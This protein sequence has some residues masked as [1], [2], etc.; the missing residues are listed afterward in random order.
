MDWRT[1]IARHGDRLLPG[2]PW[3]RWTFLA[4]MLLAAVLRFW[5]Y[6]EIPYTHDEISALVR[7]FPTLGETIRTGVIALDTHPPGVQVFEWLW[8]RLFGM[9]EA[10]VK[11]PFTLLS[12]GALVLLFRFAMAWTGAVPAL[13]LTALMATLQ[14]SV[15]YGQIARP[16]AFGLFTTALLAD[17]LTRYLALGRRRALVGI[18][19]AAV[20]SA[21]THHFALLLAF[22]MGGSGLLLLR[23]GQRKP[24]LWMVGIVLLLYLPNVPIFI[25]Q[26]G[27]GGLGGWL[28]RPDRWWLADHAWWIAHT[29]WW[30]AAPLGLLALFAITRLVQRRNV[31]GNS[32]V[33]LFTWGLLPIAIGIGYSLW[34][35]PVVQHS[36]L[37]FSFPYLA[38]ALLSGMRGVP[39]RMALPL[40]AVICV[41]SVGTL[42]GTRQHY[43]VF[44]TSKYDAM[45]D[46]A[47]RWTQGNAGETLVLLDA[48][49]EVLDFH[50]RQRGLG[51]DDV[52]HVRLLDD[53]FTPGRLDTLL[54][55]S[56]AQRVFYGQSNGASA[57]RIARIQ[58]HFPHLVQRIDMAEGQVFVLHR[59]P[60]PEAISDRRFLTGACPICDPLP[61][62]EIHTDLPT[63][64]DS[65]WPRSWDHSGREY[66]VLVAM[67]LDTVAQR[68]DDLVEIHAR[69][70]LPG[71]TQ[72]VGLVVEL[73][74]GDSTV[75]YR[76]AELD[77]LLL[78]EAPQEV[79]LIVATRPG[80]AQLR[81]AP[82]L[83]RA[84]LHNRSGAAIG[85]RAMH[86]VLREGNPVVHALSG[87]IDGPWIYRPKGLV[88]W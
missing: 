79:T 1:H 57:E 37:L 81:D 61:G 84:Y 16:Y 63:R 24:Y 15:M 6:T 34:R 67:A 36:M 42:I 4:L 10:A 56:R 68:A 29:S 75:F 7:L 51:M 60:V 20:L 31:P 48:P 3:A 32:L 76:T 26:L 35:E 70:F 22:L 9:E 78:T 69:L 59:E 65:L 82:L 71:P 58:L 73:K 77:D 53:S 62:W 72:D 8:T 17:Q 45:V 44:Y 47:I 30:L 40:V 5:R 25:G 33:L 2:A 28:P 41:L 12:L 55:N 80:D 54:A 83:L 52:P 39:S 18:A 38:L 49:P 13:L 11:L 27:L 46:G 66:G 14:Y 43:T 88:G 86:V 74:H 64:E 21:Y 50:L 19:V 87:P 23:P 85:V